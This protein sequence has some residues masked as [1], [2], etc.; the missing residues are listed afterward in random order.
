MKKTFIKKDRIFWN[1]YENLKKY[2]DGQEEIE[3]RIYEKEETITA[4]EQKTDSFLL[5]LKGTIQIY[6]MDENGKSYSIVSDQGMMLLGDMEFLL[7]CSSP[8]YT[9]ACTEVYGLSLPF[10]DQLKQD[11]AFLWI[12]ACNLAKN[13]LH[14]SFFDLHQ[15]DLKKRVIEYMEWYDRS[16]SV[17]TLFSNLHC[18]RR[19]LQRVLSQLQKEGNIKRIKKGIYE[20]CDSKKTGV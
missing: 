7:D 11:A 8:Y 1:Q 3:I 9:K 17:T 6:G 19:H 16:I 15:N 13:Q 10:S 2:F 12:L 14:F 5:I 20:L 18:S 4:M